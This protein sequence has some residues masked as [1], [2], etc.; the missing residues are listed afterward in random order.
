[1]A[2]YITNRQ[3]GQ[4]TYYYPDGSAVPVNISSKPLDLPVFLTRSYGPRNADGSVDNTLSIAF[5]QIR[6]LGYAPVLGTLPNA[7]PIFNPNTQ[8]YELSLNVT[9]R[10]EYFAQAASA[11]QGTTSEERK[12]FLIDQLSKLVQSWNQYAEEIA[13]LQTQAAQANGNSSVAAWAATVGG[14][15]IATANPYAVGAG[16]VLTAA[17][18]VLGFIKKRQDSQQLKTLQLRAEYVAAEAAQIAAYHATYS[19]ELK[20]SPLAALL[21]GGVGL[22][23]AYHY[24]LL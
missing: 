23:A 16:A 10:P 22:Y 8:Q 12:A 3:N 20:G 13:F 24:D 2:D 18:I 7:A 17:S 1:M 21:I 9:Y 14:V 4:G 11:Y 15:A 6:T 5:D 19:K